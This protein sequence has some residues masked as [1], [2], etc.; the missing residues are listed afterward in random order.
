MSE[1]ER[2]REK[3]VNIKLLSAYLKAK[4]QYRSVQYSTVE[5]ERQV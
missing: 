2:K 3:E 4:I 1:R 5:K